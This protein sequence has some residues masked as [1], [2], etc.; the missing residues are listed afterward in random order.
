MLMDDYTDAVLAGECEVP[1]DLLIEE[2][3]EPEICI[4][5]EMLRKRPD[6]R[7]AI[8]EPLKDSIV[9]WDT[10]NGDEPDE[11]IDEQ[12]IVLLK[13]DSF[14]QSTIMELLLEMAD[15]QDAEGECMYRPS[16]FDTDSKDEI[17]A[18]IA[19]G[20]F[21]EDKEPVPAIYDHL[22]PKYQNMVYAHPDARKILSTLPVEA[23]TPELIQQL[24]S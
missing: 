21:R 1:K 16:I 3:E 19:N 24:C 10:S 15:C 5:V 20:G 18:H 13:L 8:Y 11:Y 14:V 23:I 12:L 22:E 4:N 2:V 7:Q 6:I 17:I 9:P